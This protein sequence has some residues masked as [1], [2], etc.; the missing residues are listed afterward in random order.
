MVSLKIQLL[1]PYLAFLISYLDEGPFRILLLSWPCPLLHSELFSFEQF[2]NKVFS[3]TF[4]QKA[5]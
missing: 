5:F 3:E 4:V 2:C 1:L